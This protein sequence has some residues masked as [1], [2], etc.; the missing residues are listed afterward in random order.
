MAFTDAQKLQA[1]A[2]LKVPFD[3]WKRPIVV[4]K[5]PEKVVQASQPN[6]NF[7]YPNK[8]PAAPVTYAPASGQ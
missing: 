4:Y 3:T 7:A 5:V 6:F 8:N 2:L 1:Q